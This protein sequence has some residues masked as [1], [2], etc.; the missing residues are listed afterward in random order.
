MGRFS[1]GQVSFH[2][3]PGDEAKGVLSPLSLYAWASQ[4]C[5][6]ASSRLGVI[7]GLGIIFRIGNH[8]QGWGSFHGWGSSLG[9]GTWH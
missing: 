9:L 6:L 4:A 5:T 7:S 1:D 2:E 3:V 8:L